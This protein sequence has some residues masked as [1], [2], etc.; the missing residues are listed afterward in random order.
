MGSPGRGFK[1]KCHCFFF[2]FFLR[3]PGVAHTDA[4]PRRVLGPCAWLS[5]RIQPFSLCKD[6]ACWA[7]ELKVC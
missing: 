3:R 1:S 5:A 6:A 7:I 4:H 2:F